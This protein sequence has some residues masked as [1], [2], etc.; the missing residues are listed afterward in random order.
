MTKML[1]RLHGC[2]G[3]SAALLVTYSKRWVFL[4]RGSCDLLKIVHVYAQFSFITAFVQVNSGYL[5]I[6]TI[7]V[8]H[9]I[10]IDLIIS[11][12]QVPELTF[13]YRIQFFLKYF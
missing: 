5:A 4:R 13:Y 8:V 12:I 7:L 6:L 2:T 9:V 11:K 3:S 10:Q 1:I